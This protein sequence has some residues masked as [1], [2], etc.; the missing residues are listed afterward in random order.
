MG[1]R[2]STPRSSL[3]FWVQHTNRAAAIPFAS[4]T[5]AQ[6]QKPLWV[7]C[8]TK[9]QG[10]GSILRETNIRC[11]MLQVQKCINTDKLSCRCWSIALG[12]TFPCSLG[13]SQFLSSEM[14]TSKQST[15]REGKG[16]CCGLLT[17]VCSLLSAFLALPVEQLQQ[18]TPC[19]KTGR[20][21]KYGSYL[22]VWKKLSQGTS[23]NQIRFTDHFLSEEKDI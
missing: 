9:K 16:K 14:N 17:A 8:S 20:C 21:C 12:H 6:K 2:C 1:S 4:K 19:F 5:H 7:Q 22:S 10:S 15:H 3:S 11:S 13:F 23:W 18:R